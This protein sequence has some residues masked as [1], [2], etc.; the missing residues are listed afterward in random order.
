MKRRLICAS[1][2]Q[3]DTLDNDAVLEFI[4]AANP[5]L[6]NDKVWTKV[7]NITRP[8]DGTKGQYGFQKT[9]DDAIDQPLLYTV[10]VHVFKA[11]G[12]NNVY[13]AAVV[14]VPMTI[15]DGK[16]VTIDAKAE[17]VFR[18]GDQINV[19]ADVFNSTL[20]LPDGNVVQFGGWTTLQQAI[21]ARDAKN[22]KQGKPVPK[23][24]KSLVDCVSAPQRLLW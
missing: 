6:L 24:A 1:T 22:L 19:G 5:N 14:A 9:N 7:P 23:Q 20:T 13:K 16:P 2:P 21:D 10:E 15:K 12:K 4:K 17:V 3:T 8:E 11:V 18:D